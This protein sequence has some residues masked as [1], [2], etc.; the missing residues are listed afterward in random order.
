MNGT[1]GGVLFIWVHDEQ[2]AKVDRLVVQYLNDELPA[3]AAAANARAR[4]A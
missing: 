2:S 3:A 4:T 1:S